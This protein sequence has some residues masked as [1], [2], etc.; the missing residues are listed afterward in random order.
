MYKSELLE[1]LRAIQEKYE[2]EV[3]A[4]IRNRPEIE[5]PYKT[6][7]GLPVKSLYSPA[8]IGEVDFLKDI[9]F[10]VEEIHRVLQQGI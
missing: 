9:S 5:S 10:P 3:E 7:S 1:A 4:L 2:S 8:D 6:F